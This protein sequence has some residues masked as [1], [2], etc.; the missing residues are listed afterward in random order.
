MLLRARGYEL[1]HFAYSQRS[2]LMFTFIS[3]VLGILWFIAS[4]VLFSKAW[5]GVGPVVLSITKSHVGQIL[6]MLIVFGAIFGIPC[7][8]YMK[9]F[10]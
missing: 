9:I 3:T 8:L 2:T 4:V 1:H 5:S 6:A 7:W 10:G